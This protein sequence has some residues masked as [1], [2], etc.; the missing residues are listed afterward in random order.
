MQAHLFLFIVLCIHFSETF[1]IKF[2]DSSTFR[3]H[4]MYSLVYLIQEFIFIIGVGEEHVY[5]IRSFRFDFRAV[6]NFW[7][8]HSSH[9][10]SQNVSTLYTNII[11]WKHFV[12]CRI[13]NI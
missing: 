11:I 1:G 12:T 13:L 6:E 9:M 5:C 3:C 4:I 2:I 8:L 10:R 7:T